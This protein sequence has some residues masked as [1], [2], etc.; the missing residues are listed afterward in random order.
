MRVHQH[1]T[2]A[3]YRGAGRP[4]ASYCLERVV[5]EAARITGIDPVKLRKKNLIPRKAMPYKT[6]I[7]TTYD[8]GD[9]PTVVEK[10]LALADYDGFKERKRESKKKG[11]L[12]GIGI[13]F[14]LE[15][16]G[17]TPTEGA[18]CV[19]RRRHLMF[20]MNV[21]S[22]G[23]SHATIFPRLVAERSASSR[24][25]SAMRMATAPMKSRAMPRSVRAPR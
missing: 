24:S 14:V 7:G 1:H 9:F 21:Q 23:Q 13:C 15:H 2:T 19:P 3:P 10:G 6:P 22:T 5:D 17:G 12:R 16:A 11:L 8:C 25:R 20:T 18:R 4:E